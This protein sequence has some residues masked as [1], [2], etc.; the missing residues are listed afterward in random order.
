MKRIVSTIALIA[1]I[2]VAYSQNLRLLTDTVD[3]PDIIIDEV[4]VKSPK[5]VP[6]VKDVPASIALI[7]ARTIENNEISSLTDISST[8]PN[9]FMLDYGSKLQSSAFIRGIGSRLGTP[10]LGLYVDHVPYSEKTTF[11]FDFFDIERVEV[12]RG[13]REHFM[14]V[15]PWAVLLMYLVNRHCITTRQMFQ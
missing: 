9:F 3:T 10:S 4:I 7:S 12:L 15:T 2:T 8:I 6:Q 14:V 13:H 1:I 5:E 11:G